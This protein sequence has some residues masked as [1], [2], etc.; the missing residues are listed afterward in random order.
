MDERESEQ[1]E[2][3]FTWDTENVFNAF[4]FQTLDD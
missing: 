3:F 4:V 1:V 2:V